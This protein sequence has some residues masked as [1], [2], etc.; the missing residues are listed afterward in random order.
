MVLDS[1][2]PDE[3]VALAVAPFVAGML[4]RWLLGRSQFTRWGT[5]FGTM[6]FAINVLLTPYTAG[7]RQGLIELG[8]T[9]R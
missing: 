3:R 2:T 6:W 4:L 5:A 7:V 1:F 8:N 9:F